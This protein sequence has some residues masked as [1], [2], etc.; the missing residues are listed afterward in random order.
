MDSTDALVG[1]EHA[2]SQQTSNDQAMP[3]PS[4][5]KAIE[6]R[7]RIEQQRL[8]NEMEQRLLHELT[9][10]TSNNP[11]QSS[12][13]A[14]KVNG[15]ADYL[16]R[17]IGAEEDGEQTTYFS[18]PGDIFSMLCISGVMSRPF[19]YAIFILLAKLFFYMVILFDIFYT[20]AVFPQVSAYV[21]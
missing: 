11:T 15:S 2:P 1:A 18:M 4:S 21:A 17:Y 5:P 6:D 3:S 19:L 9:K 14:I 7:L 20:G 10:S 16:T 12:I 13:E 8:I